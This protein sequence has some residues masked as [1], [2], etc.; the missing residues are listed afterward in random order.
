MS[1]NT[2]NNLLVL[3]FLLLCILVSGFAILKAVKLKEKKQYEINNIINQ[4]TVLQQKNDTVIIRE[5]VSKAKLADLKNE[6]IYLLNDTTIPSPV[7]TNN[8]FCLLKNSSNGIIDLS[9]KKE[10][11]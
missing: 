10:E 5:D 6:L 8:A 11:Q 4:I 9:C 7:Y 1:K 2:V 3:I